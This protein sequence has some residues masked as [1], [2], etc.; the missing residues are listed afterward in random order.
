MF[1]KIFLI[2]ILL[3]NILD[4]V[5]LLDK[6]ESLKE[7]VSNKLRSISHEENV[8]L[9]NLNEDEEIFEGI[10]YEGFFEQLKPD[11]YEKNKLLKPSKFVNSPN[12]TYNI[13]S[14]LV[15]FALETKS[16]LNEQFVGQLSIY[17]VLI[18]PEI[19]ISN[20]CIVDLVKVF[21]AFQRKELW[22]FKCKNIM[23]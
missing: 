15:K 11:D 12:D 5:D 7:R 6:N 16:K 3:F 23:V 17:D 22:S 1:I 14:R 9:N 10:S 4:L 19:D 2:F 18:D 13:M 8:T 20:E 21:Q